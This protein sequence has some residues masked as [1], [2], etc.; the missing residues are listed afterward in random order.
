MPP[1]EQDGTGPQPALQPAPP[2]PAPSGSIALQ[3]GGASVKLT[4]AVLLV[5][6]SFLGVGS[7]AGAGGY[8]GVDAASSPELETETIR[9]LEEQLVETRALRRA[10]EGLANADKRL[11]IAIR[12]IDAD[13]DRMKARDEARDEVLGLDKELVDFPLNDPHASD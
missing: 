7:V 12:H 1:D 9:I 5:L 8:F 10:V 3:L 6:L 11:K 2:A 13:V 4:P